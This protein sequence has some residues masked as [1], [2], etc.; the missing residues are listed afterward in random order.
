MQDEI[1]WSQAP[2]DATHAFV[3]LGL[4]A[5]WFK[6]GVA[7]DPVYWWQHRKSRKIGWKRESHDSEYWLTNEDIVPR[8]DP[9]ITES[10]AGDES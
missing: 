1:P 3:L 6:I 8:P 7:S 9:L 10:Y 2:A 5:V 4:D